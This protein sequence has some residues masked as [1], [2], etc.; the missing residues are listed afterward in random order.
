MLFALLSDFALLPPPPCA[1][2]TDVPKQNAITAATRTTRLRME[3]LLKSTV[4]FFLPPMIS[5]VQ[6]SYTPHG[7][8]AHESDV[9]VPTGNTQRRQGLRRILL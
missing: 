8:S 6:P 4:P 2:A 5:A 7:S 9:L 1:N 3:S